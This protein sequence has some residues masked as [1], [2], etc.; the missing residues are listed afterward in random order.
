M[1]KEDS[2]AAGVGMGASSCPW[3]SRMLEVVHRAL[4]MGHMATTPLDG[5]A[6]TC[7]GPPV[8][9]KSPQPQKENALQIPLKLLSLETSRRCGLQDA[10]IR[11]SKG[12]SWWLSQSR[13]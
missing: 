4:H 12:S 5:K 8:L 1:E 10:V 13:P 9:P 6:Q 3:T 2:G 11:G 7:P